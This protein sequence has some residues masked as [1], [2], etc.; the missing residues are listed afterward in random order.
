M[1]RLSL[2]DRVT[3]T[4]GLALA[5]GLAI[6]TVGVY[7]LVSHRLDADQSA[8]LQ[9]RVDAQRATLEFPHTGSLAV[10]DTAN[11][12]ALDRQS[13]IYDTN[14][15]AVQRAAAK[16]DVQKVADELG[17]RGQTAETDVK[18]RLRLRAEPATDPSGKQ[19][20]T[21]VVGIALG[22]YDDT[23]HVVVIATLVIDLF[24]LLAGTLLVRAAV[25][26]ALRPVA[27]MTARAADWSEHD[28]DRRFDLGPPHDELTAL[29]ATLD[30]LLAR[31]GS[32]M[33]HEQR[34]S[35]EVAHELRTPLT[36]VRGEAELA[37]RDPDLRPSARDALE[38]VLLGTERMESVI[39]TLLAA[40][41]GEAGGGDDSCDARGAAEAASEA[42]RPSAEQANVLLAVEPGAERLRVGADKQLVAQALQPLIENAIRHARGEVSVSVERSD[43]EV[44]FAVVDDGPGVGED[45]A[46]PFEPGVS[47]VGSAGLGLPLARRLARSCGGDVAAVPGPPGRFELRLPAVI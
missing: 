1:N 8:A 37:L 4:S 31:I 23:E 21:V 16:P 19:R 10:R 34:F 43:G 36:G 22:P 45:A 12:E 39:D 28:L 5:V 18:D 35:A 41:R 30:G 27:D 25:E 13:W 33:R 20:G 6:L 42:L 44:V 29:S 17:R 14:G 2:R 47:S 40:A 7:A 11:D 3:L 24:V 15:R 46:Q 9:E 32:S 26:R 38:R